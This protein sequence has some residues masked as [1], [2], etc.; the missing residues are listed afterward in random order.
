[1]KGIQN[2]SLLWKPVLAAEPLLLSLD[3][4]NIVSCIDSKARFMQNKY[5][6]DHLV[7]VELFIR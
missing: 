5:Q 6:G 7:I 2:A 3:M 1:M 4:G